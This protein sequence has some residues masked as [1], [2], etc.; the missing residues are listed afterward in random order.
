M[1]VAALLV[2][3]FAA[4]SQAFV[5]PSP[6]AASVARTRGVMNMLKVSQWIVRTTCRQGS[7]GRGRGGLGK[8]SHAHACDV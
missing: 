3:A 2:A 1:R 7:R 6:T 8:G 5:V 4:V